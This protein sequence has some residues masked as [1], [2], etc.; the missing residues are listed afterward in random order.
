MFLYYFEKIVKL[1][2]NNALILEQERELEKD[3]EK[4]QEV[5]YKKL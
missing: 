2:S 3:K 1:L 5:R 4:E